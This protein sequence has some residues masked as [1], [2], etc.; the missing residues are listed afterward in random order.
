MEPPAARSPVRRAPASLSV[1][2][3][4]DARAP[5]G[6]YR[7]ARTGRFVAW[8]DVRSALDD[9]L[10]SAGEAMTADARRLREGAITLEQFQL[11]F[12]QSIKSVHITSYVLEKGGW[13]EL[14][15]ADHGRIGRLLYNPN[16]TGD[17]STWGQY[18]YARRMFD[19]IASGK[20]PLDGRLDARVRLYIEAGRRTYHRAER[21][22]MTRAGFD[23]ER[24]RLAPA[25]HC[26][27]RDGPL[28]GCVERAEASWQT[29]G[30]Y[31]G[32][33]E[34]NCRANDRCTVE[35]RNTDTSEIFTP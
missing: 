11:R 22:T 18:Q 8:S 6:R 14:T 21:L 5:K 4:W 33:G 30:T 34:M 25:D 29:M 9:T 16:A 15:P 13:S 12:E 7:D 19:E 2:Y 26:T 10:R 31:G 35:Y 17:T 1:R 32:I 23:E 3:T 20:Q 28:G 27:D 24:F